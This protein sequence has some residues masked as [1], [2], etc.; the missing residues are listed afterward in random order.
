MMMFYDPVAVSL[1]T[2]IWTAGMAA[3]MFP[4]IT[5]MI[6]LYNRMIKTNND[7]SSNNE[8]SLQKKEKQG[9]HLLLIEIRKNK[10]EGKRKDYYP[11][12]HFGRHIH[13]R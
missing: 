9:H 2:A 8:S 6:L 12:Y 3:M 13:L 11:L 5:P 7:T 10:K 1:F 4:A